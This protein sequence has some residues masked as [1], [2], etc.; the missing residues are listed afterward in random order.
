M[1]LQPKLNLRVSQRQV[2]TPGLVQMVS[3]LALNKLELKD[4]INS[5]MVE[6]PVLEELEESAASL[7]ERTGIEGDR[8]RSAEAVAD[9]KVRE[10]KDPFDEIDFGSYFQDYLDPGYKT[11]SNFEEFDKPSFE[12]FLSQPSTLSDHLL[13]QLG[14]LTLKPDVRGAAELI[15]GNLDMNGYLTAS[16][17]E[18]AEALGEALRAQVLPEPIPFD[19][20]RVK[21]GVLVE[22]AVEPGVVQALAA[23]AVGGREFKAE[24][25]A[26]KTA[27]EVV[28]ALDPVGVGARDLRECLLLQ[29]DAQKHEAEMM[30]RR[31]AKYADRVKLR[32]EAEDWGEVEVESAAA[33]DERGGDVFGTA[34]HIVAQCLGLLQKKDMRELTK[35]CGKSPDEVQAAVEFIRTLDP[36]AGATVQRQ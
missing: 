35:S 9:E 30:L 10:E 33:I 1:Y 17:E 15:V 20:H 27:L 13:W 25:K 8:E 7:D 4:M 11:A 29:I 22:E 24:L 23:E 12:H 16:E 2:L 21:G 34:R 5:E 32:A 18:L 28:H 3:V 14:S 26:V 31:R 19:R 36:E 6:N